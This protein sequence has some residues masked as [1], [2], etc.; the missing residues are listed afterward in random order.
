MFIESN[1]AE[2]FLNAVLKLGIENIPMC[3]V[4]AMN[5][6]GVVSDEG[7]CVLEAI[8]QP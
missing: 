7:G 1:T 6:Q 2:N 3:L 4:C 5:I 8:S